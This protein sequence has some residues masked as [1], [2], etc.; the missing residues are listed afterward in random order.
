[1]SSTDT[2]SEIIRIIDDS[3]SFIVKLHVNRIFDEAA[4]N[5]LKQHIINYDIATRGQLLVDKRVVSRLIFL[6]GV[7]SNSVAHI[8]NTREQ[9][10]TAVKIKNA[11]AEIID[12]MDN[13]FS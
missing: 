8:D 10:S 9:S 13:L 6:E 5:E 11:H 7:F 3:N 1:M 12:L 4:Y 2:I